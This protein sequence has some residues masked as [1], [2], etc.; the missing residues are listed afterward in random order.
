MDKLFQ[1]IAKYVRISDAFQEALTQRVRQ[2]VFR[3]K[4]L[5]LDAAQVCRNSYFIESGILRLYYLKDGR[6]ISEFF[7]SEN[8]WM[9]SPRSF[10]QQ[11][12]DVYYIDAIE[13]STVLSL[14]IR[15]L[16]YLFDH[17]PEMET[18]ARMDMGSTFG[19]ML[20]RLTSMRFSSAKEKYAHF[21]QTYPHIYHR[22]PLGMAASYMGITQETL[23][24]LRKAPII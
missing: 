3:K 10:M 12:T 15:D 1:A 17:F 11:K 23:S 13:D 5:I 19:Y 14:N 8:D 20:E 18:Y 7:S 22:I 24:R 4:E 2:Q 9:N 6:E 21:L 16:G